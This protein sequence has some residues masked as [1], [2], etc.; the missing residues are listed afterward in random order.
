MGGRGRGEKGEGRRK[1]EGSEGGGREEGFS[2]IYK[3][4]TFSLFI[5]VQ[6]TVYIS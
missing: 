6:H 1:G 5:I 2:S 4:Y 3:L